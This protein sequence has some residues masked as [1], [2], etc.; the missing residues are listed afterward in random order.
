MGTGELPEKLYSKGLY[1]ANENDIIFISDLDEI[2][3][4]NNVNL[5]NLKDTVYV[6]KQINTMYKFNRAEI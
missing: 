2:P 1:D 5:K 6:F 3:N 4:L